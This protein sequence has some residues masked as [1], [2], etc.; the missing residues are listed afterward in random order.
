MSIRQDIQSALRSVARDSRLKIQVRAEPSNS[1][2]VS[3]SIARTVNKES[4]VWDIEQVAIAH[5]LYVNPQGRPAVHE[6]AKAL[7]RSF[8]AVLWKF[9]NLRKYDPK[10]KAKGARNA[11]RIDKDIWTMFRRQ[12]ANYNRLVRSAKRKY[13][14]S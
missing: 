8:G 9:S 10:S 13:G 7:K 5:D 1:P 11:S 3:I 4:N 12:P 6:A 2:G 14:L